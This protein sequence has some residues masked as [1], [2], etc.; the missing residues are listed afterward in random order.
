M[1]SGPARPAWRSRPAPGPRPGDVFISPLRPVDPSGCTEM[2]KRGAAARHPRPPGPEALFRASTDWATPA[3]WLLLPGL[4]TRISAAL[5]GGSLIAGRLA[6]LAGLDPASAAALAVSSCSRRPA[7]AQRPGRGRP[8]WSP[9]GW[10]GTLGDSRSCSSTAVYWRRA[11]SRPVPAAQRGRRGTP[12]LRRPLEPS[13]GAG[14]SRTPTLRRSGSYGR[15]GT[16][17]WAG[18]WRM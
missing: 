1:V 2:G 13:P 18:A 8:A 4:P 14:R 16:T 7:G 12:V 15:A 10:P 9:D 5:L 11:T 17:S 6:Q 3:P